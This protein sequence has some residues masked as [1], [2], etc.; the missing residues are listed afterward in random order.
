MPQNFNGWTVWV[1]AQVVLSLAFKLAYKLVENAMIGWGDDRIAEQ[2]G[3]T[4]PSAA[5]AF[6]WGTP[7]ALAALT[8]FLLW[9]YHQ[10]QLNQARSSAVPTT[11]KTMLGPIM[12]A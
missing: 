10:S 1:I 6:S 11:R 7:I 12:F 8:L 2:F 9:N 4:S 5:T 3:I